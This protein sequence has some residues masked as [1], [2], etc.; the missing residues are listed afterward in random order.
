MPSAGSPGGAYAAPTGDG[1]VSRAPL[2]RRGSNWS[3]KLSSGASQQ[4]TTSAR[5]SYE[6]GGVSSRQ[7]TTVQAHA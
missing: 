7:N 5:L 6:E 2:G 4:I 3:A 1:R